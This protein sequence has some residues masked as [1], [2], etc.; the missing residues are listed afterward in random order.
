M[1]IHMDGI[2]PSTVR[3][4]THRNAIGKQRLWVTT[5]I[6]TQTVEVLTKAKLRAPFGTD[7]K[8]SLLCLFVTITQ[9]CVCA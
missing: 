4:H 8:F 9:N 5:M 1:T 6:Q 2:P 7:L 3:T